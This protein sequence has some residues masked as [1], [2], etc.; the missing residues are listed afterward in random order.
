MVIGSSRSRIRSAALVF[1]TVALAIT[2]AV[3]V[4]TRTPTALAAAPPPVG[5]EDEGTDCPVSLPGS[6]P[7]NAKLPDPFTRRTA[8]AS[9][10]SRTGAA[11]GK[12][13]RSWPSGTSTAT[14]RASRPPSPVRSRDQHHG[15]RHPTTAGV[16]ASRPASAAQ[17]HRARSRPSS[18]SAASARTRPPSRAAGV[19][20]INY[21]PLAVG[22]EG[23]PR[24]NKQGA[25]YSIYGA[26]SRPACWSP[27]P[28]A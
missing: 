16:P 3:T 28:G 20:V 24:N 15:E 22:K 1:A 10:P 23:T 9:P 27:G 6:L 8:R 14:S 2:G 26:T 13:S 19:A 11:G 18:S 25:F 5:V 17:R 12:R 4:L 7:S 21:D